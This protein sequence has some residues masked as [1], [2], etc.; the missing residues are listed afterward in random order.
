VTATPIEI[1]RATFDR[2]AH[3]STRLVLT[4]TAERRDL[5]DAGGKVIAFSQ[6]VPL[7]DERWRHTGRPRNNAHDAEYRVSYYAV[8]TEKVTQVMP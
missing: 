6:R 8:R 4:D 5:L 1:D 7:R 2:T 3:A